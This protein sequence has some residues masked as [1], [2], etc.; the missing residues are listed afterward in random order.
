MNG[1]SYG[2]NWIVDLM[3]SNGPHVMSF[4]NI[5]YNRINNSM[6]N[7]VVLME[8][9]SMLKVA[10]IFSFVGGGVDSTI[11]IQNLMGSSVTIE[12]VFTMKSALIGTV[13]LSGIGSSVTSSLS[14]NSP[15]LVDSHYQSM[16]LDHADINWQSEM[17][18]FGTGLVTQSTTFSLAYLSFDPI[19]LRVNET[20]SIDPVIMPMILPRPPGGGGGNGYPPG[21][22]TIDSVSPNVIMPGST[23]TITVNV[24]GLGSGGDFLILEALNET[25]GNWEEIKTQSV[26]TTN[27]VNILWKNGL[28]ISPGGYSQYDWS[29]IEIFA[30]NEYGN[31]G[32][33]TA[34]V[35]SETSSP[36]SSSYVYSS[37]GIAIGDIVNSVSMQIPS[38]GLGIDPTGY[39]TIFIPSNPD[40]TFPYE[41]DSV[42]QSVTWVRGSNNSVANPGFGLD[43][44]FRVPF[45]GYIQNYTDSNGSANQNTLSAFG[46][47]ITIA[48]LVVESGSLGALGAAIG[49]LALLN[50]GSANDRDFTTSNPL[51]QNLQDRFYYNISAYNPTLASIG[52]TPV[53]DYRYG[54]LGIYMDFPYAFGMDALVYYANPT[55]GTSSL[56]YIG[57]IDSTTTYVVLQTNSQTP[58]GTNVLYT[59]SLTLQYTMGGYPNSA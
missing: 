36:A 47:A 1:Q 11:A 15:V 6:Q 17:S 8:N 41:I 44:N 56:P 42:N 43:T 10:E 24:N 58:S 50:T 9:N 52:Y 53:I 38:N 28:G 12:A 3:G 26:S 13:Q 21:T 23:I 16:V 19:L 46:E 18:L 14:R 20:Y 30:A 37:S 33:A 29:E 22:T 59:S 2:V 32:A 40:A 51:N 55:G 45:V 57:V 7:S 34:P 49:F 31:G 54:P 48:A 35:F 39:S 27:Y 5:S 25:S 4:S